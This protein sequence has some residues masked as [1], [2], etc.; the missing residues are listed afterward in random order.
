LA[1][2]HG[3]KILTNVVGMMSFSLF[4][5]L[6]GSSMCALIVAASGCRQ[7]DNSGN[8]KVAEVPTAGQKLDEP[9]VKSGPC[10]IYATQLSRAQTSTLLLKGDRQA[11]K[12]Q[13]LKIDFSIFVDPRARVL[14]TSA[15][16][17]VTKALDENNVALDAD[18]KSPE[19]QSS[20]T[21]PNTWA[22][23]A[24]LRLPQEAGARLAQVEGVVNF[25]QAAQQEVWS[26]PNLLAARGASR[27]IRTATGPQTFRIEA[28]EA[29]P[30]LPPAPS[31]MGSRQTSGVAAGFCIRLKVTRPFV[32]PPL[33]RSAQEASAWRKR[34]TW[35]PELFNGVRIEDASGQELNTLIL[36]GNSTQQELA[37]V[38]AVT[39]A[40]N[41]PSRRPARLQWTIPTQFKPSSV[42]F[43]F[44]DLPLP[45]LP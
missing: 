33:L 21:A 30:K 11:Q 22:S 40:P 26:V 23:S 10:L 18:P 34:E 24:V 44:S 19:A 13:T 3:S 35:S 25:L 31:T 1:Q 27:T 6:A 41:Q 32:S 5:V 9:M 36:S 29:G 12:Q 14:G 39:T 28:V 8:T 38:I 7:A 17:K 43:K 42:P 2:V 16:L 45:S 20:Q 15:D 4:Q 37:T